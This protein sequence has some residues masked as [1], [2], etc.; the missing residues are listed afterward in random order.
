MEKK[1]PSNFKLDV[2]YKLI[3]PGSSINLK[4]KTHTYTHT[5]LNNILKLKPII[6][7]KIL[8]DKLKPKIEFK[9]LYREVK[10]Y[11]KMLELWLTS[12]QNQQTKHS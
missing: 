5:T 10:M 12:H 2:K 3:N 7:L 6:E 4:Q 1:V 8:N 11:I 9:N